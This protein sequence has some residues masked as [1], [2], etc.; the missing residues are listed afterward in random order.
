M[1]EMLASL[2]VIGKKCLHDAS[3]DYAKFLKFI[4]SRNITVNET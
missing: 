3:N 2:S 4:I 1:H